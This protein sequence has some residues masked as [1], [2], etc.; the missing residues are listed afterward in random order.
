MSPT[1]GSSPS[2]KTLADALPRWTENAP[3][4]AYTHVTSPAT[5]QACSLRP[6]GLHAKS[7][8]VSHSGTENGSSGGVFATDIEFAPSASTSAPMNS[9]RGLN[10]GTTTPSTSTSASR[11]APGESPVS[12]TR[13][14]ISPS[15]VESHSRNAGFP[16]ALP[17]AAE[18][19]TPRTCTRQLLK[20]PAFIPSTDRARGGGRSVCDTNFTLSTSIPGS[21]SIGSGVPTTVTTSPGST[22][23]N[24]P[25]WGSVN[26]VK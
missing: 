18:T 16:A 21:S 10:I 13:T 2:A 6:R 24:L 26:V 5:R 8:H 7:D 4:S 11:N 9:W 25:G 3:S 20:C 1:A 22:M 19:P 17:Y 12:R 15:E 23:S 14:R